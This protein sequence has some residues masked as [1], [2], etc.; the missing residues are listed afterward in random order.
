[1]RIFIYSFINNFEKILHFL[2]AGKS[3]DL[4]P[5]NSKLFQFSCQPNK[6][7]YHLKKSSILKIIFFYMDYLSNKI[8][9]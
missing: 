8:R 1:M 7:V 2:F 9:L 4:F 6:K 5:E 3:F